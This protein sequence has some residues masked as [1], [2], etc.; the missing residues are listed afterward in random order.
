MNL[1]LKKQIEKAFFQT[2]QDLK[3]IKEKEVF[4]RDFLMESEFETQ[5][6]RLAIAY[7]LKKGRDGENIMQNLHASLEDVKK[8]ERIMNTPGI[9]LALKYMEAEEWANVWAEKI[10]KFVRK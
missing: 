2:L 6:K 3:N 9:K 4:L 5:I 1:S 8:I 10:K 7:W